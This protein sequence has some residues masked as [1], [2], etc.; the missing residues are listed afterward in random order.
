MSHFGYIKT[1][2]TYK[3]LDKVLEDIQRHLDW[4]QGD[5]SWMGVSLIV[6]FSGFSSTLVQGPL[7]ARTEAAISQVKVCSY[8]ASSMDGRS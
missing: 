3:D 8:F 2:S 4:L 6:C 5:E 1:I 7:Q